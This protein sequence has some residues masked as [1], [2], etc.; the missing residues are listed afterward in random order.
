MKRIIGFIILLVVFGFMTYSLILVHGWEVILISYGI[1]LLI[2]VGLFLII[3][4]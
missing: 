1:I 2:F 4:D 3:S